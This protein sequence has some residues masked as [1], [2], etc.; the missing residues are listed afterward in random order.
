MSIT[1]T[2]DGDTTITTIDGQEFQDLK[3]ALEKAA[4][5]DT[6]PGHCYECKEPFTHKNVFTS[7]GWRETNISHL[8]ERCWDAMFAEDDDE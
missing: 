7:A 8:C 3:A 5:G 4:R 2:V 1:K 6:P